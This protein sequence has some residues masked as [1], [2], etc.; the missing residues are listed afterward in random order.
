MREEGAHIVRW[1]FL[2]GMLLFCS[3]M[4]LIYFSNKDRVDGA[5]ACKVSCLKRKKE[6][7]FVAFDR[8]PEGWN[9]YCD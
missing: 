9:C 7:T 1:T 3:S 6:H 2:V 8:D 5:L 4:A